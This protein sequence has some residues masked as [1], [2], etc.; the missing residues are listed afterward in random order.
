M[1]YAQ[2]A[3]YVLSRSLS[4]SLSLYSAMYVAW[5]DLEFGAQCSWGESKIMREKERES[6]PTKTGLLNVFVLDD[7]AARTATA[8][9]AAAA[10]A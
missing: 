4:L 9:A 5:S 7:V 10:A 6:A 2:L 8:T 3:E 1:A